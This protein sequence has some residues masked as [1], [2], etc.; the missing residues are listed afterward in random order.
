MSYSQSN[1]LPIYQ[2]GDFVLSGSFPIV[3]YLLSLNSQVSQSL[4]GNTA[5]SKSLNGSWLEF[6][7]YRIQELDLVLLAQNVD[8]E[9]STL[10]Q[11]DLE[12]TL[13]SLNNHL[14]LRTFLSGY[15]YSLS[16]LAVSTSLR[17][18]FERVI[19][20]EQRDKYSHVT[21]WFNFCTS[22][23]EVVQAFGY[24]KFL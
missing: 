12:T 6:S 1:T 24:V 22:L 23:S 8:K 20:K 13:E 19:L 18:Y 3:N 21:R 4:V 10:A 2:E 16:D 14:Q 5:Q 9:A 7:S 15:Q 17:P 11:K